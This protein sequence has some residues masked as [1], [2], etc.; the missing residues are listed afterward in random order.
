MVVVRSP[1]QE[2]YPA[3]AHTSTHKSVLESA[4]PAWTESVHMDAPSQRH[5]QQPVS[6]TAS[7]GVVKQDKSFRGSVD[8][9]KTR[10]DPQRV[11]MCSGE[12][13]TVAA[14]GKQTQTMASC[15]APPPQPTTQCPLVTPPWYGRTVQESDWTLFIFKPI[16][17][18]GEE[19]PQ[20]WFFVDPDG[21]G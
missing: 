6:G 20:N 19:E 17:F 21:P 2:N 18:C 4:N 1:Y 8:T 9:T 16:A 10:S 7:P 5:G 11:G 13:P 15:Q 3:G 14:K 12:R